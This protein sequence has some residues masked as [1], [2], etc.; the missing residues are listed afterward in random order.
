MKG[1][2]SKRHKI[3]D[4]NMLREYDFSKGVRGKHCKAYRKGHTVEFIRL[5]V[6]R[7]YSILV[8]KTEQ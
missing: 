4:H 1:A 7:L 5:T 6:P 3:D 8:L 2:I